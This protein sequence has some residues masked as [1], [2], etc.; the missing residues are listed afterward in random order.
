MRKLPNFIQTLLRETGKRYVFPSE[1]AAAFWRRNILSYSKKHAI[2]TD[3]IISWDKFKESLFRSREDRRP[4][5]N[6][7]RMLFSE[8]LL[9]ENKSKPILTSLINPDYSK[10]SLSFIHYLSRIFPTLHRVTENKNFNLLNPGLRQDLLYLYEKY[11]DFLDTI[12]S[13]EPSRETP[14]IQ[15]LKGGWVILFPELITDYNEFALYLTETDKVKTIP[16]ESVPDIPYLKEFPNSYQEYRVLFHNIEKLLTLGVHPREI[17]VTSADLESAKPFI[18]ELSEAY[19]LPVSFRTGDTLANYLPGKLFSMIQQTVTSRFTLD[20]LKSL[21]LN[22]GIPWKNRETLF[23]FIKK[24]MKSGYINSLPGKVPANEQDTSASVQLLAI[25][26]AGDFSEL[27]KAVYRFIHSQIESDNWDPLNMKALQS[28]M[29]VLNDLIITETD[30]NISSVSPLRFWLSLLSSKRYVAREEE[31]KIHFYPYRPAAGIFPGYHFITGCSQRNTTV[32]VNQADYLRNDYAE[33]LGL[34]RTELSDQFIKAYWVSGEETSFTYSQEGFTGPE[35]S[36]SIFIEKQKIEKAENEKI[37]QIYAADNYYNEIDLWKTGESKTFV[38]FTNQY[39]GL[40]QAFTTALQP[41]EED[42]TVD[43]VPSGETVQTLINRLENPNTHLLE[44][45]P[46]KLET[47]IACPFQFL[48]TSLLHIDPDQY[49]TDYES[50]R[51]IGSLY[52]TAASKLLNRNAKSSQIPEILRESV[53]EGTFIP[54][55]VYWVLEPRIIK[56]LQYFME[57]H[58]E[59]FPNHKTIDTEAEFYNT[60]DDPPVHLKCRIDHLLENRSSGCFT[61]IDYKLKNSPQKKDIL[62]ND[63]MAPVSFQLP[64]YIFS[65][66]SEGKQIE[67]AGYYSFKKGEYKFLLHEKKK[68]WINTDQKNE[69]IKHALNTLKGFVQKIKEGDYRCPDPYQGCERGCELR[70]VCR[71]RF[72]TQ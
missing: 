57:N 18:Q 55:P 51:E 23:S 27:R 36:P 69:L 20:S 68:S 24:L 39:L 50:M 48:L 10:Y 16:V 9:M 8:N 5:N 60:T 7:E 29:D 46:T 43:T 41:K 54:L 66:E 42:F 52:H 12:G 72:S 2:K 45:S 34:Q 30:R 14:D 22:Q 71:T 44:L 3:S 62:G 6:M 25:Q 63:A 1:V 4:V 26:K 13:F 65:A 21:F 56:E 61:I 31:E 37:Q 32:K 53:S 47:Y 58:T 28:S 70:R 19:D 35:L 33:S 59:Q 67:N 64:L 11:N 17:A 49:I 38:P 15:A 40:N